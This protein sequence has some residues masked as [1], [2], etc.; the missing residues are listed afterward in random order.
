MA[1]QVV[2]L[3][4]SEGVATITLNRPEARNALTPQMGGELA[5][6]L[7]QVQDGSARCL[8]ITGV[9]GAFCAGADIQDFQQV[10]DEGG[11]QAVADHLLALATRLHEEVILRI[12]RLPIPVIASVNGVAAG[13]GFSLAL[14]AD[15][16][17]ASEDALMVMGYAGI[18]LTADGGSTYLLP[19]LI[20]HGRAMDLYLNNRVVD[21]K[22]AHDIGLVNQVTPADQLSDTVATAARR[23]ARG[24]TVAFG[25][26]KALMNRAY[27]QEE[28]LQLEAEAR[29]LADMGLTEDFREGITSFLE[30]RPPRFQGR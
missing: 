10:M 19:R 25:E 17:F 15:L 24:A 16:R 29:K 23:L 7:Q 27:E 5:N 9:G 21:A 20:G 30:K 8:V 14:A 26:V 18:G 13:A 28:F 12:R 3:G 22:H 6:A 11:Q 2:L 4:E 1:Q